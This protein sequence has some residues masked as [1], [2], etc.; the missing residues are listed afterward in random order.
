MSARRVR[1]GPA[2]AASGTAAI[3][4]AARQE[5][6]DSCHRDAVLI[7]DAVVDLSRLTR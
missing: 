5:R 4:H 6:N 3:R 7:G 1:P 2:H